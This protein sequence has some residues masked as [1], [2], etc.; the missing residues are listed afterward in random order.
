MKIIVCDDEPY[1]LDL[2]SG[3]CAR[4][5]KEFHIPITT[6]KFGNGKDVLSYYKK[7]KD[8]D[9]FILDIMMKEIDGLKI[10]KAVRNDG[11]KTKIIFLTSALE[12]A[13]TGYLFG[14][15]RYWMKPLFYSKF[16]LEMQSLCKE[17]KKERNSYLIDNIGTTIEKVYYD[18]ILYI[19]TSNRKICVHKI[20][21]N[22]F[23][24]FTLIDYEQKLDERFF[25]CHAAY[26]VNMDFITKI[27]GLEII[28]SSDC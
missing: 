17:I 2:I 13:P 15:S 12:F 23:S 9:L 8:I 21:S 25:R 26:I 20:G 11:S 27:K 10:A 22:Y 24:T 19:E 4:F 1:F 14:V 28:L 6:I 18:E 7:N 3:Y 5:E 16:S